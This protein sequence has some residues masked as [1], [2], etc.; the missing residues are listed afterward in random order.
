MNWFYLLWVGGAWTFFIVIPFAVTFANFSSILQLLVITFFLLYAAVDFK[1]IAPLKNGLGL[2]ISSGLAFTAI[3]SLTYSVST[4]IHPICDQGG[5]CIK[6]WPH[7]M[8]SLLSGLICC[9]GCLIIIMHFRK[10]YPQKDYVSNLIYTAGSSIGIVLLA[11]LFLLQN[12]H[13]ASV[14]L[15][16][17]NLIMEV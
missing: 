12:S 6:P 1:K 8:L 11:K 17:N 5:N 10:L 13:F 2:I 9:I 7:T 14:Y 16:L 4:L 15:T 3:A